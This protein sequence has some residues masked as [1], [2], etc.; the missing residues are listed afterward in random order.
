MDRPIDAAAPFNAPVYRHA[1]GQHPLL[2]QLVEHSRVARFRSAELRSPDLGAL[3]RALRQGDRLGARLR[4]GRPA[5]LTADEERAWDEAVVTYLHSRDAESQACVPD[6]VALVFHHTMPLTYGGTPW[7]LHVE[8]VTTLF[9]PFF[10]HGRTRGIELARHP[11]RAILRAVLE[12]EDCRG[13]LTHMRGTAE[14][15]GRVFDSSTIADKVRYAPLGVHIAA[16]QRSAIDGAMTRKHRPDRPMEILFTNSW[17]QGAENFVTRGG[18]EV[19]AAFLE[20]HRQNPSVHLTIRSVIP[21]AIRS[22]PLGRALLEHPAISVLDEPVPEEALNALLLE[23]DVFVLPSAALHSVSTLRAMEYGAVCVVSDLPAFREFIDPGVTGLVVPGRY[24]AVYDIDPE[25]GWERDDYAGLQTLN[26]RIAE[27]LGG[28]LAGL[29]GDPQRR[30]SIADAARGACHERFAFE[31]FVGRFDALLEEAVAGGAE[32]RTAPLSGQPDIGERF[33]ARVGTGFALLPRDPEPRPEPV[34]TLG[35]FNVLRFDHRYYAVRQSLGAIQFGEDAAAAI[36]RYGS[37]NVAVASDLATIRAW[38]A[39]TEQALGGPFEHG[40]HAGYNVVRLGRRWF[41]VRQD[42]GSVDLDLDEAALLA[43]FPED[44]VVIA[45][46]EA[47]V[48][49]R[50]DRAVAAWGTVEAG[51]HGGYNLLRR[52]GRWF[53]VHQD[54]GAVDLDR[55]E[56]VLLAEQPPAAVLTAHSED[57]LKQRIDRLTAAAAREL[58]GEHRGFNL[59]HRG[60][61]CYG[62]RQT[63]GGLDLSGEGAEWVARYGGSDVV[64]AADPDTLRARIDAIDFL[65]GGPELVGSEGE[66]NIVRFRGQ[67][68]GIRQS[69]GPVDLT[70]EETALLERY[71]PRDLLLGRTPEG[72]RARIRLAKRYVRVPERLARFTG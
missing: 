56:A 4:A 52:R 14:A 53:A 1:N 68:Y 29:A 17:H 16:A 7:V 9:W 48:R 10:S 31:T 37:D 6:D 26:P 54:L 3:Y 69:L 70:A 40:S 61:L 51:E 63:L 24:D 25:T 47:G 28:V 21:E 49:A 55:A 41:G 45:G 59:L 60:G 34:E 46:S 30:R 64:V 44:E 71:E 38:I 19:A 23:A 15:L 11:A 72:V 18:L 65:L 39:A 27:E 58:F 2:R 35:A 50:I 12:A 66:H 20:L 62:I 5:G 36:D 32:A 22:T 33:A 43:R 13:I 8:N 57:G 42:I 67:F